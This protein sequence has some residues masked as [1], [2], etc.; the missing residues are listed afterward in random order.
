MALKDL[1]GF[2]RIWVITWLHS[3]KYW[4][5]TVQPPRGP[6]VKRGT[7]PP[8]APLSQSPWSECH[9]WHHL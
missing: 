3:N 7:W 2:D 4:N 6:K 8:C 1:E 5:P 9:H